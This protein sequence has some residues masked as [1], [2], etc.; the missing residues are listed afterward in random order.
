MQKFNNFRDK[1]FSDNRFWFGISIYFELVNEWN[2]SF[3]SREKMDLALQ[4]FLQRFQF[5]ATIYL[6]AVDRFPRI[7][8]NF[9]FPEPN[10]LT[11]QHAV[12][13]PKRM[14][15][16]RK[17]R[18]PGVRLF[19]VPISPLSAETWLRFLTFLRNRSNPAVSSPVIIT[20]AVDSG[21]LLKAI[22]LMKS[23]NWRS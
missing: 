15:N 10:V 13:N 8:R 9:R 21:C 6:S 7:P 2:E 17:T 3:L 16:D 23:Q 14:I 19:P 18:D 5:T 12:L 4:H 11:N 1:F 20:I 22:L